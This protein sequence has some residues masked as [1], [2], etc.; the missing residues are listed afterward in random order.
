MPTPH[1]SSSTAAMLAFLVRLALVLV[2]VIAVTSSCVVSAQAAN[3]TLSIQYAGSYDS[4]FN[5]KGFELNAV[6][7]PF[8]GSPNNLWTPTD[9]HEFNVFMTVTGLAAGEDLES[10]AFDVAMGPG[11]TPVT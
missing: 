8:F 11:V 1:R 6:P 2:A 7:A 10:V 9:I 5:P 4:S 3:I